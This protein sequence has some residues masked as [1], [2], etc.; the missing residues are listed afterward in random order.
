MYGLKHSLRAWFHKFTTFVRFQGF[1]QGH[2]DHKL[3]TKWS[4]CKKIVLIVY[5]DNILLSGDDTTLITWLK[6][7]MANEFEIKDLGNLNYFLGI[8][9]KIKGKDLCYTV[10][11]HPWPVKRNKYD[12]M[13]TC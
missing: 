1:T 2:S 5:V 8:G 11:I 13:Y 4:L 10:E 6:K 9:G 7:K 3:F 12:W